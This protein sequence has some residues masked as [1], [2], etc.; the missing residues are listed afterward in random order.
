MGMKKQWFG[1][2]E[3]NGNYVLKEIEQ[4]PFVENDSICYC[5]YTRMVSEMGLIMT[6]TAFIYLMYLAVK[7]KKYIF[8][9]YFFILLYL[10]VQFDSYAFYTIWIY[11]IMLKK[12]ELNEDSLE[13]N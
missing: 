12:H 10:Y 13:R 3:V 9:I 7:S 1:Y 6:L 5:L 11:I 8:M 4:L 2:R